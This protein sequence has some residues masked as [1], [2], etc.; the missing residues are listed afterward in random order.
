MVLKCYSLLSSQIF[1]RMKKTDLPTVLGGLL[2]FKYAQN[3]PPDVLSP[4][5][6]RIF[7]TDEEH[8]S[9]SC[10]TIGRSSHG[11]K[12]CAKFAP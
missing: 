6:S 9:S 11:L 4:L 10:I 8:W 1:L 7:F 12:E 3:L 5:S 2:G